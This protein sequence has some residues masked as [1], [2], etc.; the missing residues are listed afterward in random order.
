MLY[1]VTNQEN[2]TWR[3]ILWGENVTHE[4]NNAN[5]HFAAYDSPTVAS[6]MYPTYDGITTEPKIWEALAPDHLELA[7]P[8]G[9]RD[10]RR[11]YP[12]LTTVQEVPFKNPSL[13]QRINF[14]ILCSMNLVL[15]PTYRNWALNYLKGEDQTKETAHATSETLI[16]QMGT[17]LPAEHEYYECAHPV[18]AAVMLDQPAE[19]CANAAHRA[20]FDSLDGKNSILELCP[21]LDLHQL[22]EIA[23]L[24]SGPEIA[25]VLYG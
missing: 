5:Y 4:E 16:N 21:P 22:A 14:A 10:F 13:E 25:E 7:D 23:N 18:L 2:K 1:L 15:H 17:D 24:I 20:Y 12:K 9:K 11:K 19:F 8:V 6:Y 3:D